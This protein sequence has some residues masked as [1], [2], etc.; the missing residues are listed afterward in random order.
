MTPVELEDVEVQTDRCKSREFCDRFQ[1]L[2]VLSWP[3]EQSYACKRQQTCSRFEP[4]P[5]LRQPADGA[6]YFEWHNGAV[7]RLAV[8]TLRQR[9]VL[10]LMLIGRSNKLIAYDLGVSL[11]TVENHRRVLMDRAGVR[12]LPEL[13]RLAIAAE[14]LLFA[15]GV[16]AE[17][18][19][20]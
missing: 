4:T 19:A 5:E 15:R 13:V 3:A 17:R 7:K 10:D 16:P 18:S 14:S 8:L 2:P 6:D 12:T 11:R 1:K 9:E 20:A